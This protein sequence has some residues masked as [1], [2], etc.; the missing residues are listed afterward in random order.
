MTAWL[1]L[2][3]AIGFACLT[4]KI[5]RWGRA[6]RDGPIS[7]IARFWKDGL[8]DLSEDEQNRTKE[9][10]ASYVIYYLMLYFFAVTVTLAV[11]AFRTFTAG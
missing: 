11:L 9:F 1:Y 3:L 5:F 10:L 8:R 7:N 6:V 4:Y 2:I